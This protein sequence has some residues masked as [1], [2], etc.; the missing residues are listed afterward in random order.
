MV[1]IFN[2]LKE[3]LASFLVSA[4]RII[5]IS[6]KPDWD[7]YR[8]MALVTGLGIIIIGIVGYVITL[9]LTIVKI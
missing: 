4:R 8:Q 2:N 5:V 9:I 3:G 7:S 6:H 1:N